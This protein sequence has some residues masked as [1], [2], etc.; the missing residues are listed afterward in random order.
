M[1]DELKPDGSDA[2]AAAAA[3]E[4]ESKSLDSLLASWDDKPKPSSEEKPSV[5]GESALISEVARLSYEREM[6][7]LIPV[8]KGD[9]KISDKF[10][11]AYMNQRANDDPR[12]RT[13]WD[14]R[15]DRRAEFDQ[16][17]QAMAG[18]LA[19]EVGKP[20]EDKP[21][22]D[23]DALAAAIHTAR[24]KDAGGGELGDIDF[25]S[26]SDSDFELKKAEVFRLAETGK[27]K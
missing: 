6:D 8:V 17:M 13:L 15:H 21:A 19:T 25:G 27:L 16:A 2:Q 1:N 5:D 20:V 7:K 3:E 23:K 24:I 14:N 9:L 4:S 22:D 26:L 18:E 10:V 11:E 12:L